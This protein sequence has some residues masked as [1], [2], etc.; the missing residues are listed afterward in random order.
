MSAALETISE[1]D[2]NDLKALEL[3]A[4]IVRFNFIITFFFA[5]IIY[6]LAKKN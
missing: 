1:A 3:K 4:Q 2:P 6:R 5:F